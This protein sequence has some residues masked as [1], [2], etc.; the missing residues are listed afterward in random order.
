MKDPNI[1]LSI[2]NCQLRDSSKSIDVICDDLDL[3]VDELIDLLKSI[4]YLYSKELNQFVC[5]K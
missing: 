4:G 5:R 2:V 3:K 1:L